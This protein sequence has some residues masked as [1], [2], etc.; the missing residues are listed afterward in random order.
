MKSIKKFLVKAVVVIYAVIMV[1]G[2]MLGLG[3][4]VVDHF[5]K[6]VAS[7]NKSVIYT[8]TSTTPGAVPFEAVYKEITEVVERNTQAAMKDP[9]NLRAYHDDIYA[10]EMRRINIL[11]NTGK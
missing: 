8:A 2:V 9:K 5:S 3:K 6:A 11:T 4:G 1:G 7:T 10:N